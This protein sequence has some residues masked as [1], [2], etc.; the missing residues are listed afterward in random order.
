VSF[1]DSPWVE[2][3]KTKS[4]QASYPHWT[5]EFGKDNDIPLD[6][7][8]NMRPLLSIVKGSELHASR[9]LRPGMFLLRVVRSPTTSTA[10]IVTY[11][12]VFL[13]LA[14][15]SPLP[16]F[17][18][19]KDTEGSSEGQMKLDMLITG[20]RDRSG[21]VIHWLKGLFDDQ[22][23]GTKK[24]PHL[25]WLEMKVHRLLIAGIANKLV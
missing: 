7:R 19:P 2:I 14:P 17:A 22:V 12:W 23:G 24:F 11:D 8:S 18:L 5:A 6:M 21:E 10:T 9:S 3:I 13:R 1:E 16:G 15:I 20:K 4:S 25:A